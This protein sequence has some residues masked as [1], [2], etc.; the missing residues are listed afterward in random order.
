[1]Y[2]PGACGRPPGLRGSGCSIRRRPGV[3]RDVS[4]LIFWFHVKRKRSAHP[5]GDLLFAGKTLE[6][7]MRIGITTYLKAVVTR[8]GD[9]ALELASLKLHCISSDGRCSDIEQIADVEAD[10]DGVAG[11][12]DFDF[13]LRFF[14]LGVG[15]DQLQAVCRRAHAHAAE[16][17]VGQNGGT[18]HRLHQGL[19]A[20]RHVIFRVAGGMTRS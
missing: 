3:L 8:H 14:L 17:L 7:Q 20:D 13:F 1:M 15:G 4:S 6:N 9:Q 11:V 5:A 2:M 18:L 12:I 16:F 19:A 10:V